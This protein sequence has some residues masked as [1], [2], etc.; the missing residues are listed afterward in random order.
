MAFNGIYHLVMTHEIFKNVVF[1]PKNAPH[2]WRALRRQA[3]NRES[4]VIQRSV[5]ATT[6]WAAVLPVMDE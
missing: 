6:S 3:A 4:A 2:S 5:E 1:L